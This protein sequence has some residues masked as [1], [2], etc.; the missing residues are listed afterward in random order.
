MVPLGPTCGL[1]LPS[2][3]DRKL[4]CEANISFISCVNVAITTISFFER[5]C[6]ALTS[7][8]GHDYLCPSVIHSYL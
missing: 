6:G 8:A 7:T 3:V 2:V 5:L 4:S 1:L